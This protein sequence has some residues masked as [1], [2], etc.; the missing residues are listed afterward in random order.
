MRFY[1][2][3]QRFYWL[4]KTKRPKQGSGGRGFVKEMGGHSTVLGVTVDLAN[5]LGIEL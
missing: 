1:K 2:A 4:Q 5:Y 3:T